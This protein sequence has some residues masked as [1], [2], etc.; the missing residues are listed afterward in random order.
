MTDPEFTTDVSVQPAPEPLP[1]EVLDDGEAIPAW[2]ALCRQYRDIIAY[3][4]FGGCT[5]IVNIVVYWLFAHPLG[6]ATV[7]STIIAWVASVLFAY[8]TNRIWV[9]HSTERSAAGIVREMVEFFG[10]RL[11][12]GALDWVGMYVFVDVLHINDVLMKIIL[13]VVVIV[14]NYVASKFVIFKSKKAE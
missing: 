9:F 12:T 6:V 4:F 2:K 3:V 13:N 10:C 7:P 5:T 1:P 8:V 14:L 11:G